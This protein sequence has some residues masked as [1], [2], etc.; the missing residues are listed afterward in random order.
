MD[1]DALLVALKSVEPDFAR[2]IWRERDLVV[3]Y[4]VDD[5]DRIDQAGNRLYGYA[6]ELT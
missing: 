2:L 4:E 3:E 5:L 6:V 1:R